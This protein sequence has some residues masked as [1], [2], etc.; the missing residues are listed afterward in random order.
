MGRRIVIHVVKE[1][2]GVSTSL[3]RQAAS[4]TAVAELVSEVVT[5]ALCEKEWPL[6]AH[7]NW[8]INKRTRMAAIAPPG[9]E[10]WWTFHVGKMV[11]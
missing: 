1:K 3:A 10:L 4:H 2:V 5:G 7:R 6:I 9:S 11:L 8:L